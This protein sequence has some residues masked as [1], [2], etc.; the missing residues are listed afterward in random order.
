MANSRLSPIEKIG[1]GL[2]DFGS[3]VVFQTVI[4]LLPSFYTDVFGQMPSPARPIKHRHTYLSSMNRIDSDS[5]NDNGMWNGGA[6]RAHCTT[7]QDTG[8]APMAGPRRATPTAGHT[9]HATMAGP[10]GNTP[11]AGHTS[12]ETTFDQLLAQQMLFEHSQGD[13]FAHQGTGVD[14][15]LINDGHSNSSTSSG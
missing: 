11:N 6:W 15:S 5:N 2:G 14:T 10:R 8:Y 7:G 12:Q 4:I 13:V 9:G 1:Y 3:N